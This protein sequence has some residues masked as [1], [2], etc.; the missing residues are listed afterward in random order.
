M[1][2]PSRW[3]LSGKFP[4]SVSVL[5]M[6]ARGGLLLPKDRKIKPEHIESR[7]S[8]RKQPNRIHQPIGMKGRQQDLILAKKTREWRNAGNSQTGDEETNMRKGHEP[9]QSTHILHFITVHPV[10]DDARTKEK[11]GLKKSMRKKM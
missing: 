4:D 9:P 6:A 1:R 11:Q 3:K 10:N 5:N 7:Q 2:M 8:R